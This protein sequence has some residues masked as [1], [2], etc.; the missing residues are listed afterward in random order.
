MHAAA[1]SVSSKVATT[2]ICSE[3]LSSPTSPR[4]FEERGLRGLLDPARIALRQP[5]FFDQTICAL[6]HLVGI[7][8]RSRIQRLKA[9]NIKPLLVTHLATDS[10]ACTVREKSR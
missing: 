5:T 10:G 8:F 2:W 7:D 6:A 1:W 9:G 3:V 4:C